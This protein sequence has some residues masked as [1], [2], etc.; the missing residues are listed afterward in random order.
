[1]LPMSGV[2][3]PMA[4]APGDA[5]GLAPAADPDGAAPGAPGLPGAP[6]W[7]AADFGAAAGAGA[8][9]DPGFARCLLALV[10]PVVSAAVV[11]G[12]DAGCPAA[13]R[14][15]RQNSPSRAAAGRDGR[16][17]PRELVIR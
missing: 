11:D 9:A 2:G 5:G 4:G 6:D 13:A 10:W 1:M 16:R 3:E 17:R 14:V 12:C 7:G 15:N 8:A